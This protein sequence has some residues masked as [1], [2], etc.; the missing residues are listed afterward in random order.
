MNYLINSVDLLG[1]HELPTKIAPFKRFLVALSIL[2]VSLITVVS[3]MQPMSEYVLDRWNGVLQEYGFERPAVEINAADP[4]FHASIV[5]WANKHSAQT[6]GTDIVSKFVTIAFAESA[7]QKVDPLLTLAVMAVESR[8]DY[9]ATSN[10]GAK[11]LMQIIPYWHKDK[12]AIAQVYDPVSNIKAGTKILREYLT[13]H[14]G[15]VSKALLNYN[16]AL[17]IPGAN[18]HTKVLAART[19]LQRFIEKRF[20]DNFNKQ[21]NSSTVANQHKTA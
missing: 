5:A 12:I 20:K 11:G 17:G 8:F 19:D 10:S 1:P 16:G 21:Y 13:A 14:N 15:D 6:V 4:V 3:L 9:M 7:N 18:Y 2:I